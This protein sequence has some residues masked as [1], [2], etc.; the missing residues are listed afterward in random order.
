MADIDKKLNLKIGGDA[1]PAV[2][3]IQRVIKEQQSLDALLK[4]QNELAEKAVTLG[5]EDAYKEARKAVEDY[6]R[7]VKR[8]SDENEKQAKAAE[9]AADAA[10]RQANEQDRANREGI[11]ESSRRQTFS[12]DNAGDISTV[13]SQIAGVTGSGA[14][15]AV[16]EAA[17]FLEYLPNLAQGFKNL[18]TAAAENT[19]LIGRLAS[20]ITTLVPGLGAAGGGL[21]AMGA[22]ILPIAAVA[23]AASTAINLVT[24]ALQRQEEAAKR[25]A[26]ITL[27]GIDARAAAEK[28]LKDGNAELLRSAQAAARDEL[29]LA[30]IRQQGIQAARDQAIAA[31]KSQTEVN[32]LT[33]AFIEAGNATQTANEAYRQVTS[34]FSSAEGQALLFA[35]MVDKGAES[36]KDATD[37]EKALADE[38]ERSASST[39][40][41]IRSVSS[42]LANG[43]DYAGLQQQIDDT[44][45]QLLV[46]EEVRRRLTAEGQENTAAFQASL[47]A[48][49]QLNATLNQLQL[50]STYAA[51]SVNEAAAAQKTLAQSIL[52]GLGGIDDIIKDGLSGALGGLNDFAKAASDYQKEQQVIADKVTDINERMADQVED[53]QERATEAVAAAAQDIADTQAGAQRDAKRREREF[54]QE[55]D[56][57]RQGF[58]R[59]RDAA[60][61]NQDVSSLFDA[62]DDFKDDK[63]LA[64]RDVR[65]E[66]ADAAEDL[67]VELANIERRRDAEIAASQA[68][69]V[70]I[71]TDAAIEIAQIQGTFAVKMS[72]YEQEHNALTQIES[73][74]KR[75]TS[76]LGGVTSGGIGGLLGGLASAV[77]PQGV[78]NILNGLVSNPYQSNSNGFAGFPVSGNGGRGN[79]VQSNVTIQVGDI[80]GD[81]TESTVAGWIEKAVLPLE[82]NI[83]SN[84]AYAVN[85]ATLG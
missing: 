75:V 1:T 13:A 2:Q 19:G 65:D 80:N 16:S 66:R 42:L 27:A 14:A 45:A 18:G 81:V 23:L 54:Q 4:R 8:A 29:D 12:R 83:I 71:Q 84:V 49:D 76:A 26:E 63:R 31:G 15:Q 79:T 48:T 77:I 46:E 32:A 35:D 39:A 7:A 44:N 53:A 57:I 56:D 38:R 69:I 82:R 52:S 33:D 58:K 67:A 60:I 55:L 72:A 30:L 21:V 20:S 74:A 51:V 28:A 64:R 34:V 43:L 25:S 24:S 85:A 73:L 6:Q 3:A 11:I 37:A 59:A 9:R 78:S 36:T 47:Q 70:E 62:T 68:R 50:N 10:R 41:A 17:G 40:S 61:L 5:T 22:A